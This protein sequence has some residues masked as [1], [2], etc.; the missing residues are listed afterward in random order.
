MVVIGV[1]EGGR[2]A[3]W[4]CK[5]ERRRGLRQAGDTQNPEIARVSSHLWFVDGQRVP[6]AHVVRDARGC[7]KVSHAT[8]EMAT[9]PP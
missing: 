7:D 5:E 8:V 6:E 9:R 1:D 4:G 2:V 3:C